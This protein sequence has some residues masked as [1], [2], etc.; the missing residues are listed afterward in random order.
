MFI[1]FLP[2]NWCSSYCV[3]DKGEEIN[4]QY[5]IENFLKPV[6]KALENDCPKCGAIYLKILHDNARPHVHEN[7]NNFLTE[8]DIAL[9]IWLLVIFGFSAWQKVNLIVIRALKV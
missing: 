5:Y 4:N 8:H 1:I 2:N 6:V 7:V 3:S 9:Q